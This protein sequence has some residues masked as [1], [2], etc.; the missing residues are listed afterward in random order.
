M[1]K[2]FRE[3]HERLETFQQHLDSNMQIWIIRSGATLFSVFGGLALLL[4]VSGLFS[5]LSF[6]VQQRTKEIG[7]RMALGATPESVFELVLGQALR[8]VSIGVVAGLAVAAGLT[9]VLSTL[10]YETEPLDP[11]TFIVTAV[12][13]TLVATLASYIPARRGTRIAPIEALRAE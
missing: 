13:L 9:R 2:K 1:A 11:P 10:L 6:L 5:V 7:V 3:L 8:L 12:L 4:T